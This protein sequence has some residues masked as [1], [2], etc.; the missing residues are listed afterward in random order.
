MISSRLIVLVTNSE[1]SPYFTVYVLGGNVDDLP[2]WIRPEKH[3]EI[4]IHM[5]KNNHVYMSFFAN[6]FEYF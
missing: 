6:G 4:F 1:E 5:N 2:L 3:Y